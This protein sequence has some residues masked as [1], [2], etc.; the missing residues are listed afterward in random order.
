MASKTTSRSFQSLSQRAKK[1]SCPCSL[2]RRPSIRQ[3]SSSTARPDAP[4]ET[5]RA[6]R[7]RWSYTP[8]RMKAPYP[9]RP[10]DPEMAWECNSDPHLLDRFYTKF[11]GRGG[12]GVLSEEIKWLAV[13]HKSFDQGRRGFNDRLAFFG[14]VCP[15]PSR[16][17][18][19][20]GAVYS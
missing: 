2:S 17:R 19:L 5:D 16:A 20:R 18:I 7:P 10:R 8:E 6:E 9:A 15:A 12:D 11:L 4:S 3:F 13:T 14:M 1:T